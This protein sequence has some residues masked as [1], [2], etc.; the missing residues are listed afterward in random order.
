MYFQELC[1]HIFAN[2]HKLKKLIQQQAIRLC[3]SSTR[4]QEAVRYDEEDAVPRTTRIQ[5]VRDV[6]LDPIIHEPDVGQQFK[7]I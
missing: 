1:R 5:P 3:S 6:K 2:Q 7:V 4:L